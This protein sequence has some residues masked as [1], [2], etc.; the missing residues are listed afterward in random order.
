MSTARTSRWLLLLPATWLTTVAAVGRKAVEEPA[1]GCNAATEWIETHKNNLPRTYSE[2]IRYPVAYRQR[3][4]VTL[5]A[6]EQRKLW[7][8][9]HQLY[10]SSGLLTT[11]QAEFLSSIRAALDSMHA[12]EEPAKS[13]LAATVSDV[14]I[15]VLGRQLTHQ[16]LYVLGPDDGA[17]PEDLPAALREGLKHRIALP[18]VNCTCHVLQDGG[19]PSPPDCSKKCNLSDCTPIQGGC[20][21]EG[22][23]SCN[24]ACASEQ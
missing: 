22:D 19:L 9:Q 23:F 4:L 20:G 2:I 15:R 24:G 12:T 3:I 21:V 17:K 8:I 13:R 18:P 16:I 7:R 1:W 14:A 11:R 5:P 10:L 6:E